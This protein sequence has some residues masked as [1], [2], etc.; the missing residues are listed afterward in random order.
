MFILILPGLKEEE[1][2]V[3]ETETETMMQQDVEGVG[4][5]R[6]REV[7]R[8]LLEQRDNSR[9]ER[10]GKTSVTMQ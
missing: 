8:V 2:S 1:E 10:S 3:N 9:S 5:E 4:K 6:E 7:M